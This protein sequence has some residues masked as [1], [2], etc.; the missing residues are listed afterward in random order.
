MAFRIYL[1]FQVVVL[2]FH[3][4]HTFCISDV[5]YGYD[6]A[7]AAPPSLVLKSVLPLFLCCHGPTF[8]KSSQI[9]AYATVELHFLSPSR[10]VKFNS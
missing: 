10:E 5:R 6:I 9:A 7:T 1:N 8:I 4:D 2:H 3:L